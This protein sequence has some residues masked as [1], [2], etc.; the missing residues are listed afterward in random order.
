MP[1]RF[2]FSEII[3]YFACKYTKTNLFSA[4]KENAEM[5]RRHRA[6]TRSTV[7][8]IGRTAL[9]APRAELARPARGPTP[10]EAERHGNL[11]WAH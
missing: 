8:H 1:K 6:D 2:L 10:I 9:S 3:A 7:H 11:P 4:K 5:G